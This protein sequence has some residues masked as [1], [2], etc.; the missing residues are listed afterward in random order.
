MRSVSA[1]R[2][3]AR[4]ISVQYSRSM[5]RPRV[6]KYSRSSL[7]PSSRSANSRLSSRMPRLDV[8]A[9][10][11]E[12]FAVVPDSSYEH[13]DVSVIGVVMVNRDPL[14]PRP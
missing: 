12:D 5:L 7:G 4:S 9:I 1:L 3:N 2:S 10:E 13:V 6:R 14:Q 11:S 8:I